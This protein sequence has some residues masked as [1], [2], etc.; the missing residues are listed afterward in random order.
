[1]SARSGARFTAIR[2]LSD[3]RAEHFVG[4]NELVLVQTG[5]FRLDFREDARSLAV[6]GH[7]QPDP[8]ENHLGHIQDFGQLLDGRE[9][10][11]GG[12]ALDLADHFAGKR[13]LLGKLRL[14]EAL[15][16]SVVAQIC[17]EQDCQ[18]HCAP[19]ELNIRGVEPVGEG[20]IIARA[21]GIVI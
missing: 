14:S 20:I 1:M 6:G 8:E 15:G 11:R 13:H 18:R 21:E 5:Q 7:D 12:S 2:S 19:P 4:P 16:L 17:T 9:G 10:W 3:Q